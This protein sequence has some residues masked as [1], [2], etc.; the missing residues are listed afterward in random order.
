VD[1]DVDRFTRRRPAG[2]VLAVAGL[3][4]DEHD[5]GFASPS[6]NTVCVPLL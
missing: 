2:E 4:A 6:P 3:L 5:V 1:F